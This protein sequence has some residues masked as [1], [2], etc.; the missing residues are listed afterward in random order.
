MTEYMFTTEDRFKGFM[1]ALQQKGIGWARYDEKL[2]IEIRPITDKDFELYKKENG[3]ISINLTEEGI[4]WSRE[5]EA[6]GIQ[7][8]PLS[9]ESREQSEEEASEE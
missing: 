3:N 6:D 1:F 4:T 8:P 2:G 7:S 9:N 5:E